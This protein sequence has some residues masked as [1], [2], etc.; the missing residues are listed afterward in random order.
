[1]AAGA[2]AA[3]GRV[4]VR[5]HVAWI[6]GSRSGH[7]VPARHLRPPRSWSTAQHTHTRHATH[8]HT[9]ACA[10]RDDEGGTPAGGGEAFLTGRRLAA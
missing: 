6:T 1:M 7:C 3:V 4:T 2:L 8:G 9:H 10:G 5:C